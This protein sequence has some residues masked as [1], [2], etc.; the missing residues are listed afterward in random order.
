MAVWNIIANE[1]GKLNVYWSQAWEGMAAAPGF[2][3]FGETEEKALKRLQKKVPKQVLCTP[4]PEP[5][6]G[7]NDYV[8][9]TALTGDIII[10]EGQ[11]GYFHAPV[12]D[13]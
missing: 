1:E 2:D 6:A 10:D 12:N 7:V 8:Y 9:T 13:Q 4:T 5:R 3:T 11:I